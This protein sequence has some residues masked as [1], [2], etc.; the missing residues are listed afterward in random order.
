MGNM[1][2][3]AQTKALFSALLAGTLW[4]FG[5]LAVRY[6]VDA[7]AYRWQY[8]FFRG[9]T[10]ATVLCLYLM[11]RDGSRFPANFKRVGLSGFIGACGLVGAF[12]GFIW[13]VTLTTVANTLF[14]F[15]T[16]PFLGA[17]L[18]ILFLHE[19]V[20]PLTWFAMSLALMGILVMVY[21]GLE[22]EASWA[23]WRDSDRPAGLPS[24]RRASGGERRRPSLPP[25]PWP[26]SCAPCSPRVLSISRATSC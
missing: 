24:S 6:M 9:L 26:D 4:S 25:W 17:F 19:R 21:E 14:T 16:T 1:N 20:R 8:L 12:A 18:G 15:A 23:S 5:G 7:Q 10:I 3:T 11:A 13:A 22:P 2:N